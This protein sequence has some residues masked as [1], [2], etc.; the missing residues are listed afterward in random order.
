MKRYFWLILLIPVF[1]CAGTIQHRQAAILGMYGVSAGGG[2][3][4]DSVV[5]GDPDQSGDNAYTDSTLVYM[6][7]WQ[8]VQ[9]CTIDRIEIKLFD[10]NGVGIH[11]RGGIYADSAGV[12]GSLL[13]SSSYTATTQADG[14]PE[15]VIVTLSSP[16]AIT[17]G[18]W[19]WTGRAQ[20][21]Q[22]GSTSG[23]GSAANSKYYYW[24]YGDE[25]AFP[26]GSTNGDWTHLFAEYGMA[27]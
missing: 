14:N 15:D 27:Q 20:S 26:T 7:R 1:V 8:A 23:T 22:V 24:T 25:T 11:I 13:Q 5:V 21:A 16:V 3:T 4:S 12:P 6:S 2:C 18:T 9:T 17:S 19:Y 10:T